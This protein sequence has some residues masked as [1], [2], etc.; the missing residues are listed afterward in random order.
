MARIAEQN[1]RI[2][3]RDPA[4]SHGGNLLAAMAAVFMIPRTLLDVP[5]ACIILGLCVERDHDTS[6]ALNGIPPAAMVDRQRINRTIARSIRDERDQGVQ[7]R[8]AA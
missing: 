8:D 3:L 5:P 7:R 4:Q 6:S 2:M 1:I